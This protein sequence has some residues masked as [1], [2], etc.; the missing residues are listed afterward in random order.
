LAEG[1]HGILVLEGKLDKARERRQRLE[2]ALQEAHG[3]PWNPEVV[4]GQG[5]GVRDP[6]LAAIEEELG[7]IEEH[8][9]K[10]GKAL[11][12]LKC[13]C[14]PET[15]RLKI[16]EILASNEPLDRG[17]TDP[18]L[19]R[20]QSGYSCES[21]FLTPAPVANPEAK[22]KVRR[23]ALK[24]S[25]SR[26]AKA[27]AGLG[28]LGGSVGLG[29]ALFGGHGGQE[30][31]GPASV[32]GQTQALA[33]KPSLD[34][35]MAAGVLAR[36]CRQT[37]TP[38]RWRLRGGTQAELAPGTKLEFGKIGPVTFKTID[39]FLQ[40]VFEGQDMRF[41]ECKFTSIQ[42]RGN[43]AEDFQYLLGRLAGPSAVLVDIAPFGITGLSTETSVF[44]DE[45]VEF[46]LAQ[47]LQEALARAPVPAGLALAVETGGRRARL[48]AIFN[49]ALKELVDDHEMK[50]ALI[51]PGA[52]ERDVSLEAFSWDVAAWMRFDL[53]RRAP[54]LRPSA[55]P[56]RRLASKAL[57]GPDA[58]DF[59][60]PWVKT[61]ELGQIEPI[62]LKDGGTL[63]YTG[64]ARDGKAALFRDT[65]ERPLRVGLDQLPVRDAERAWLPIRGA[66][67]SAP[68]ACI[69][70][71]VPLHSGGK[72]LVGNFPDTIGV[73]V[74]QPAQAELARYLRDAVLL[75]PHGARTPIAAAISVATASLFGQEKKS[76]VEIRG[77]PAWD[78]IP[79]GF[80]PDEEVVVPPIDLGEVFSERFFKRPGL[81]AV[82]E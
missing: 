59:E 75:Y 1:A 36:I 19:Y 63:R 71:G 62:P 34:R 9:A 35:T 18:S 51:L 38:F 10:W 6:R 25:L 2:K 56:V 69:A 31:P 55:Y 77:F 74:S 24:P 42:P 53:E 43:W 28:L 49:M 44:M 72:A 41:W 70:I 11:D 58:F 13:Q 65:K 57:S 78:R 37:G 3:P 22:T 33:A 46:G 54:A 30:A 60:V 14:A 26:R 12:A 52:T 64:L 4:T 66:D 40:L 5:R 79:E 67:T 45:L 29:Y 76:W 50:I 73:K 82:E 21:L 16:N 39:G 68:G 7:R 27:L 32:A 47:G 20:P 48:D 81:V 17:V 80:D 61:R 23:P 15:Q 8:N